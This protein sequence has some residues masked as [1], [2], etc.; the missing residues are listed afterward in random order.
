MA[1]IP[2]PWHCHYA[3]AVA[4]QADGEYMPATAITAAGEQ[5]LIAGGCR[6]DLIAF[7]PHDRSHEA[8]ARLIA[9]A[10]EMYQMLKLILPDYLHYLRL[11][12][13]TMHEDDIGRARS[14]ADGL[15]PKWELTHRY[16]KAVSILQSIEGDRS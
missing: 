4:E 6:G 14:L 10:P 8:N 15:P 16:R 1:H 12:V 5:E 3:T 13:A 9:A 2:G 11:R 7:V